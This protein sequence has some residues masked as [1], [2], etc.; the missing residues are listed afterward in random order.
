MSIEHV[1]VIE[2]L[3]RSWRRSMSRRRTLNELAA[4]PPSELRRIASDV[5]MSGADLRRLCR[6]DHGASELLPERLRLLGLDPQFVQHDAPLLFRD[7]ARVC[8]SCQASRRCARD[9]VRGDVQAGMST[10]CLNGP[11]IDLL[12]ARPTRPRNAAA[13]GR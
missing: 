12:T 5:G 10:Y 4:C 11:S 2:R 6:S 9:L 13:P 1:G 3:R 8:A 7:L